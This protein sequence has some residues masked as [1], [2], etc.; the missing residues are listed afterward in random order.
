MVF[1]RPLTEMFIRSLAISLLLK[2][3]ALKA[4]HFYLSFLI[5]E[6]LNYPRDQAVRSVFYLKY[7]FLVHRPIDHINQSFRA[8]SLYWW[9]CLLSSSCSLLQ[10]PTS[11]MEVT[12][13]IFIFETLSLYFLAAALIPS[14][15]PAVKYV[16]QHKVDPLSS[17]YSKGDIRPIY[18][19]RNLILFPEMTLPYF[20]AFSDPLQLI[21]VSCLPL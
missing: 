7:T 6:F 15:F 17:T 4:K 1:H 8:T 21:P 5:V 16:H 20:H 9:C 2:P 14:L 12:I 19:C 18:A 10:Y 13:M 3:I 11:T